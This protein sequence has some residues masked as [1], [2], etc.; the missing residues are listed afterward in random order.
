MVQEAAFSQVAKPSTTATLSALDATRTFVTQCLLLK[1]Q[2]THVLLMAVLAVHVEATPRAHMEDWLSALSP[3][4]NLEHW[5]GLSIVEERLVSLAGSIFTAGLEDGCETGVHAALI[6]KKWRYEDRQCPGILLLPWLMTMGGRQR[7]LV[8][9]LSTVAW[10]LRNVVAVATGTDRM[11]GSQVALDERDSSR[12]LLTYQ[13]ALER[14]YNPRRALAVKPSMPFRECDQ[15]YEA[16]I[17][18]F[19]W[20]I[21]NFVTFLLSRRGDVVR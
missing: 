3:Q 5:Q 10:F 14:L 15:V 7:L 19:P 17:K 13:V 18:T 2:G 20:V 12:R 11:F 16:F 6:D 4:E 1:K 8:D 9:Y 21:N